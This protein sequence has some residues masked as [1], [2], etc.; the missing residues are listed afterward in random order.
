MY[1]FTKCLQIQ[2]KKKG[3]KKVQKKKKK[4]NENWQSPPVK[5]DKNVQWNKNTSYS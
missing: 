1:I 2:R 4:V 5:Q 3:Q